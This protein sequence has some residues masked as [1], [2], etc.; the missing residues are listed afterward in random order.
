MARLW[1][2]IRIFRWLLVLIYA[3]YL[4]AFVADR[5]SYLTWNG[6]L[7]HTTEAAMFGIPILFMFFGLVEIIVREKGGIPRPNNFSFRPATTGPLPSI[8][9]R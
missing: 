3:A 8:Q 6:H 7:F 1:M 4:I 5:S 9:K 2:A